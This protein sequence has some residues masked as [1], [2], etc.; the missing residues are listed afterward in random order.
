MSAHGLDLDDIQG[1]IVKAYGRFGYPKARYIFFQ[2]HDM[3]GGR[4]FL[5]AVLPLLTTSRPWF[6]NTRLPDA[7]TNIAFSYQGLKHLGLPTRSLHSFPEEFSMG[8]K[9]R[10]DILGDDGP[11]AAHHWDPIWQNDKC[12]HMFMS[13]NARSDTALEARYA[14]IQ[15]CLA[16]YQ[17]GGQVEQLSGHRGAHSGEMAYQDAAAVV[18]DGKITAKEHFGYTDGISDP[19]FKGSGSNPENLIGGGKPTRRDPATPSGWEP[20]ATGEFILGYR[21]ETREL[22][23]APVP[24]LLSYNGTF[25]VYRKLHENVG[26]FNRYIRELGADFP[27]GPEALVAKMSGR[28]RNGAPVVTFPTQPEADAFIAELEAA[29]VAVQKADDE[30]QKAQ[31]QAHFNQLRRRLTGFNFN[32][33]LKGARCPMGSHIRRTNPRGCL[34][35]GMKNAFST[36]GALDNRRRILRRGLPYG[37]VTNPASDDGEHGVIFMAIGSSIERQFEFV[38]Q[39]WIN[40]GN[41]FKLANQRDPLLGNHHGNSDFMIEGSS[42]ENPPFFCPRLPRFVTTRGGEYFFI[43]SLTAVR[44]MADNLVDPT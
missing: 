25:M 15:I 17:Q 14:E 44:M 43:P 31:A 20:L 29:R 34:E 1:N 19:Y 27:G 9:A 32:Q 7:T 26:S 11:S 6:A 24:R 42:A 35:Y 12:V 21:D 40:Y 38:Q 41:D 13:I 10:A 5:R 8:M 23:I 18:I 33:D 2:F 37:E 22:P 30:K 28:W 4:G 36:P 16:P 39:Q 3:D